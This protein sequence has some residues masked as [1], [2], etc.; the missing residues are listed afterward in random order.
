MNVDELTRCLLDKLLNAR[1]ELETYTH[2]R[3][4]KGYMSVSETNQLKD[5]FFDLAKEIRDR[6]EQLNQLLDHDSRGAVYRA[7]EALS[8]AAISLM[9]GRHDCPSYIAVNVDKLERSL[10]I[11]H[12]SI[13][14]LSEHSRLEEA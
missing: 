7:E 11:L 4:A 8:S 13:D 9:T 12:F 1:V 10:N 14:Y 3:K 6:G 2:M 5:H